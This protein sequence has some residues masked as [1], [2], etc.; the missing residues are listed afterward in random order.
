MQLTLTPSARAMLSKVKVRVNWRRVLLEATAVTF[1]TLLPFAIFW[2][3]WS[4]NP[5]DRVIFTGDVLV[6]AFPTRVYIHR[7]FMAGEVPLWNPYQLGG[8]PLLAD[9]QAAVYYLPNLVLSA[10]YWGRDITYTGFEALIIAQYAI[11][12]VLMYGYLRN[13]KLHPAAALLGAIAYEFNGF[14][15]GHRG[16]YSMLSVV[17]WVPGILWFLDNAW[18]AVKRKTAVAWTVGAGL[19]FSQMF[20]G[21]HPQLAFY[22]ILFIGGYFVYRWAPMLQE[23]QRWLKASWIVRWR[24]PLVQIPLRF[25]LAGLL[26]GAIS[27]VAILP[28]FELLG[29]SLRSDLSY[30][31]SV[32]YPLMPRNLISLLIPEFLD[33]SG[34]EFRIY[35]GI[36]TLVL[37]LV[38]WL[39]PKQARPERWFFTLTIPVAIIM[40]MGGFTAL[41][42]FLY[43]FVPGFSSV[44]VTARLFYFANIS[45]AVLAA[46][47]AHALFNRL[48]D[49][50]KERL[51]G[52]VHSSRWLLAGLSLITITFYMLLTWFATPVGDGFYTYE[53]LFVKTAAEDRFLFLSQTSN[54]FLLFMVLLGLSL[55]LLWLRG[56][57]RTRVEIIMVTAVALMALDISTFATQHDTARVP[58]FDSIALD[59]FEVRQLEWWQAA[60]RD[61]IIQMASELP[62]GSRI[63]NAEE[64]LP[65]NYSQ[66]WELLFSTG[67]NVLD[68]S[69]RF[70]LLT[71]WPEL[72]PK[73]SNDLMNVYYIITSPETAEPPEEG[74]T[75]VLENSQGKIWQ[76]ATL[77]QYAHFSTQIRPSATSIT[78]NGLLTLPTETPFTQ[79][80][81]AAED[82]NL[83]THLAELWPQVVSSDLYKIGT[84]GQTSPV[85]IGVLAGGPGGYSAVIINGET[86]TPEQRGM[87]IAAVN[88][89]TGSLIFGE[90]F[91]TY[92]S[93]TDSNSLAAAIN[94]L[95][96][97]TIV[98]LATYDEGTGSLTDQARAALQSLGAAETLQDA[99]GMAYGLI[100]VKGAEPGTAVE[101]LGD[102]PLAIDVGMGA[103]PAETAEFSSHLIAYEQDQITLQVANSQPGLLTLSET[104]YPGW[105]AFVNGVETP[106]LRANGM[107]RS[108]VLPAGSNEVSLVYDPLSVRVGTAVSLLALFLA[109]GLLLG[110]AIW[111][112]RPAP[113]A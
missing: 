73:V 4:P 102:T 71:Q 109:G 54:Q 39:V 24:H 44:R 49:E 14:F 33:W 112:K 45:L 21:G 38:V 87:V 74:A 28:M 23:G 26:G 37:V 60:E 113:A 31:F 35:A 75:I 93:T 81:L 8:M 2:A 25:G 19:L 79:P 9:V 15:I 104:V 10:I 48:D 85:E 22:S 57:E 107:F 53:S 50:E 32:Q 16:H 58:D 3:L 70:E 5:A 1:L 6:G 59:G 80:A 29:R 36:L 72:S 82:G 34:T 46:M 27:A 108:L 86:A 105:K 83:Q 67:Y 100:G 89:Q 66:T 78:I 95:P 40:A 55:V 18:H 99:F 56:K 110:T 69:E 63:N 42:G 65:D 76:R 103:A 62:P 13:L 30:A 106:I 11:G 68:L 84:T 77:P 92:A 51:T 7:L 97:G 96:N 101:Q 20:M 47:G 41:H 98:A 61:A 12:A 52:L 17:V 111:P 91:D 43:R 64:L 94:N 88:P 90:G